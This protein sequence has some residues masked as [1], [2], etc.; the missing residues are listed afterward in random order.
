MRKTKDE[1]W[2]ELRGG[3]RP[4]LRRGV[5]VTIRAV[6]EKRNRTLRFTAS[7]DGVKRDGNAINNRGWDFHPFSR[8]PVMLFNHDSAQP[9]I[10]H[11]VDWG[12]EQRSDG[13]YALWNVAKFATAEE[14]AFAD[15]IYRLYLGGH[16]RAESV[17]WTPKEG[18]YEPLL[19]DQGEQRGWMFQENEL[20]EISAVSLPADPDAVVQQVQRGIITPE[21]A[22]A[23][24]VRKGDLG[25]YVLDHRNPVER[26]P[27]FQGDEAVQHA[28]AQKKA[29][30][31]LPAEELPAEEPP[32][33][34][35]P[36]QELPVEEPP[37]EELPVEEPQAEDC[38]I[39]EDSVV[40]QEVDD[41]GLAA[42]D[43]EP[44]ERD[45]LSSIGHLTGVLA[46]LAR[47]R[48]IGQAAGPVVEPDKES[49]EDG[50]VGLDAPAAA[51][52]AFKNEDPAAPH[53]RGEL[54]D[55]LAV[56]VDHL[57]SS[58]LAMFE[59]LDELVRVVGD[60]DQG[61]AK[62]GVANRQIV[63][64]SAIANRFGA[65]LTALA[66]E[67]AP[68]VSEEEAGPVE[69]ELVGPEP[70]PA[71]AVPASSDSSDERAETSLST[72]RTEALRCAIGRIDEGLSLVRG[73][74]GDV[75]DADRSAACA[76]PNRGDQEELDDAAVIGELRSLVD[77][78]RTERG[79]TEADYIR[80]M[81]GDIDAIRARL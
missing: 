50:D 7:T 65:A 63:R 61:A 9:P 2:R 26:T 6:G 64:L 13:S 8:N 31:E 45:L 20:L 21:E 77:G 80:S 4:E 42:L 30:A 62:L 12:V 44:E 16:M 58:Y 71:A 24:A 48:Q 75:G 39:A 47:E 5:D 3:G 73:V 11:H 69:P 41:D 33:E 70:E 54:E 79:C 55:A 15:T 68:A 60:L 40:G 34:E 10:G 35:P 19:D 59:P 46:R 17:Q 49:A 37:A 56:G 38:V 23:L 36:V 57:R 51:S 14:Y 1:L 27:A 28:E 43:P 18:G 25:V 53:A 78:L 29:A 72:A 76:E 81:L 67:L 74:L 52:T 22:Q 66:R 32:A